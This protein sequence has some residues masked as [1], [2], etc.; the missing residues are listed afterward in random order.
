MRASR[1]AAANVM[2]HTISGNLGSQLTGYGVRWYSYGEN[3]ALYEQ[4]HR[5][6]CRPARSTGCGRPARSHW[7]QHDEPQV[8]LRRRRPRRTGRATT[9]RTRP[10]VFTESP[11]HT[12][13]KRLDAP[14]PSKSG[15]DI[16]WTWHGTDVPLQTHTAG[17]RDFDVQ[18]RVDGGSWRLVAEQHDRHDA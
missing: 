6:R 11:D 12:R 13:P 5:A 4:V 16:T 8:Q 14:G 3:I 7:A 2:S 9:G 1:M 10:L 15:R 18:Y 17:F